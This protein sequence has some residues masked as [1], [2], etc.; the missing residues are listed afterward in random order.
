MN[1]TG[2]GAHYFAPGDGVLLHF[3]WL[4]GSWQYV[5]APYFGIQ[6]G[7]LDKSH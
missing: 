1:R 2:A 5:T 3:L 6:M 7:R 4:L